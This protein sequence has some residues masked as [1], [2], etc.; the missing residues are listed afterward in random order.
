MA[1]RCWPAC[2]DGPR[3][4][5]G[6]DRSPRAAV[7]CGIAGRCVRLV[8]ALAP[9]V[10]ATVDEVQ[11]P[12]PGDAI[13][14]CRG[15]RPHAVTIDAPPAA[16]RPW[17]AQIGRGAGFTPTTSSTTP[18]SR[19]PNASCRNTSIWPSATWRTDGCFAADD[20]NGFRV[21]GFEEP[22]W[23]GWAKPGSTWVWVLRPS[24]TDSAAWSSASATDR[25]PWSLVSAPLLELGD[26]PMMRK[27]APRH[28]SPRWRPATARR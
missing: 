14:R 25:L 20:R 4:A 1:A 24:T 3:G 23:L 28:Q 16:V 2:A 8:P 10:G 12:L 17:L 9:A 11:G 7:G 6:E 21:F 27:R 13:V 5:S 15:S 19:A 18:A 26:F 22:E